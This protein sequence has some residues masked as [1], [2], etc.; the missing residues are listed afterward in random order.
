MENPY[1]TPLLDELSDR[2]ALT[3]KISDLNKGYRKL[4]LEYKQHADLALYKAKETAHRAQLADLIMGIS[5]E[6][7][8][9]IAIIMAGCEEMLDYLK[10]VNGVT[11]EAWEMEISSE[12]LSKQLD[13]ENEAA[14]RLMNWLRDNH[15]LTED[16][17]LNLTPINPFLGPVQPD[18]PVEFSTIK[19]RLDSFFQEQIKR[20][21]ILKQFADTY[22]YCDRVVRITTSMMQYGINKA[23]D[24]DFFLRIPG[25]SIEQ[26]NAVIADLI[27]ADYI[28]PFGGTLPAFQSSQPDF[29]EKF[30]HTLRPELQPF[31]NLILDHIKQSNSIPKL[32]LNIHVPLQDALR[33]IKRKADTTT[34]FQAQHK[35]FGDSSRLFQVFLI[36]FNNA[37]EAMANEPEGKER[38]L[39]VSTS[40]TDFMSASGD[41][42]SG[43]MVSIQDTG[44]GIKKEHFENLRNP[45][46]STKT[47]TGGK[48]VGLGLSILYDIV[49]KHNGTVHLDSE[50]GVGTVFRLYFPKAL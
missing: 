30:Q 29:S 26:A 4:A 23:I 31:S 42:I 10:N 39:S 46:F 50:P 36:A 45:F 28:N 6:V 41:I 35:I 18:W 47:V 7:R 40:N 34:H 43:V 8:N 15:F 38:R 9:P 17:Q 25:F 13:I 37:V 33:M 16:S 5:H 12:W 44:C 22:D 3:L 48:N 32:P 24:A 49:E 21:L 20:Q 2:E 11:S 14:I 19:P 1:D 27:Q